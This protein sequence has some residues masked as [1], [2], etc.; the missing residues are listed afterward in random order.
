MAALKAKIAAFEGGSGLDPDYS[1]SSPTSL[2]DSVPSYD[3]VAVVRNRSGGG[4][5]GG[6]IDQRAVLE[7]ELKTEKRRALDLDAR[8]H[9]RNRRLANELQSL[10][11]KNA[12]LEVDYAASAGGG[13]SAVETPG[14]ETAADHKVVTGEEPIYATSR[15]SETPDVATMPVFK[16]MADKVKRLEKQKAEQELRAQQNAK[17]KAD[18]VNAALK[19]KRDSE[20]ALQSKADQ[21][22]MMRE[23]RV[24]REE[25]ETAKLLRDAAERTSTQQR[26]NMTSPNKHSTGMQ[27][28]K[29]FRFSLTTP[30]RSTNSR[31]A[32]DKQEI[33]GVARHAREP[34]KHSHRVGKTK[35]VIDMLHGPGAESPGAPAAEVPTVEEE[36]F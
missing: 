36:E 15:P 32:H 26:R 9:A 28:E 7:H 21:E 29:D 6:A 12:Q 5:S 11:R 23:R 3:A 35:H 25:R 8:I 4:E 19:A 16:Q 34:R 1:I 14:Y 31:H 2:I 13:R 17:A 10:K 33:Y 27:P 24:R 18:R 20:A 22:A 30:L